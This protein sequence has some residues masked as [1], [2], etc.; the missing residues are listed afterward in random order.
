VKTPP[1]KVAPSKVPAVVPPKLSPLLTN[2]KPFQPLPKAPAVSPAMSRFMTADENQAATQQKLANFKPTWAKPAINAG[3]VLSDIPKEIQGK[4]VVVGAARQLA[5]AV[6]GLAVKG[7]AA[8]GSSN[9]MLGPQ[10][11]SLAR[12]QKAALTSD[13][14]KELTGKGAVEQGLKAGG[15]AASKALS[16]LSQKGTTIP[17]IQAS[18]LSG[19]AA[20]L[21]LNAVKD[22]LNLPAGALP[23]AYFTGQALVNAAQGNTAPIVGMGKQIAGQLTSASGWEQHPLI[24]ALTAFGTGAAVSRAGQFATDT[25]GLTDSASAVTPPEHLIGNLYEPKRPPSRVPLVRGLENAHPIQ[26]L[27]EMRTTKSF[28]E[29]LAPAAAKNRISHAVQRRTTEE[30]DAYEVMRRQHQA[31]ALKERQAAIT[32]PHTVK[33]QARQAKTNLT[34]P[35]APLL[36]PEIVGKDAVN[37]FI[38]GVLSHPDRVPQDIADYRKLIAAQPPETDPVLAAERQATL[39]HLTKV[40][41]NKAFMGSA[42]ARQQAY[43]AARKFVTTQQTKLEPALDERGIVSKDAQDHA[44]LVIHAIQRMGATHDHATGGLVVDGKPLSDT[45]IREDMKATGVELPGFITH[46]PLTTAQSRYKGTGYPLAET[47]QRTGEAFSRGLVDLSHEGV[48]NQ[49]SRSLTLIDSH[50]R[51]QNVFG[52]LGAIHKPTASGRKG[53]FE[54]YDAAMRAKRTPETIAQNPHNLDLMPMRVPPQFA[55]LGQIRA[56]KGGLD[57]VFDNTPTGVEPEHSTI[58]DAAKPPANT[59]EPGHYVLMSRDAVD[60]IRKTEAP[61]GDFTRVGRAYTTQ[62]RKTVLPM[63]PKRVLGLPLEQFL[64]RMLPARAGVASQFF[65]R[66]VLNKMASPEMNTPEIAAQLGRTGAQAREQVM[67]RALGGQLA[68][69]TL[70]EAIHGQAE[71]Y[72]GNRLLYPA[73]KVLAAGREKPVVGHLVS[74]WKTY[75][76]TVLTAEAKAFEGIPQMSYLGRHYLNQVEKASGITWGKAVRLQGQAFDDFV[77]QQIGSPAEVEA[78]RAVDRMGGQYS[79]IGPAGRAALMASPFGMWWVNSLKFIYGTMPHDHPIITGLL[80]AANTATLPTRAQYGLAGPL[81]GNDQVQ[82]YEQGGVPL[83]GPHGQILAQEYYGPQGT[84]TDPFGTAANMVLPQVLPTAQALG[85][86]NYKFAAATSPTGMPEWQARAA[87]VFNSIADTIIPGYQQALTVAEGGA[88][89]YDTSTLFNVQTKPGQTRS[90]GTAVQNLFKPVRLY[91]N[92]RIQSTSSK[93]ALPGAGS[94]LALPG[95]P[96]SGLSLP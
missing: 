33:G 48:V 81:Y 64:Y 84:I 29:P 80:S 17:G 19:A 32:A 40:E 93:L 86:A 53:Y 1:M 34:N 23:S 74:A 41:N 2:A 75:A 6:P 52:K 26:K 63:S 49:H 61:P 89:P 59:H 56:I 92:R 22:A 37:P 73:A 43:V 16:A 24:N 87:L 70:R 15:A 90:T 13:I 47:K 10:P 71:R 79:K 35:Q 96:G 7:L 54:N 27:N 60:R 14:P 25:A 85:G 88:T 12:A 78:A 4:G 66:R 46:K 9:Q 20:Q 50:D 68:G 31:D 39:D 44:K 5:G 45:A 38:Q 72:R 21:P 51:N 55:R 95:A 58:T 67:A 42:K 69:Q 36:K 3:A 91:P 11:A 94:G 30:L 77:K 82:G 65:G 76:H 18:G 28:D 8:L 83:G 62:F 57:D